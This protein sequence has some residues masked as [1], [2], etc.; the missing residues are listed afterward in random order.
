MKK[1]SNISLGPGAS[2]LILIFVVLS[3]T[4][5][6]MLSLMTARNDERLSRR[7]AE[8][9]ED[10]YTLYEQAEKHYAELSGLAI[11]LQQDAVAGDAFLEALEDALPEWAALDGEAIVWKET[12]GTRTLDCA[13]AV[14]PERKWI[15]HTLSTSIA[16]G[17]EG[18]EEDLEEDS[19]FE[20]EDAGMDGREEET[21]EVE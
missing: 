3:M 12:D 6:G 1:R 11:G 15:R 21:E 14:Q 10:V 5:L 13:M 20:D 2:S 7:S 9:I 19:G 17:I 16:D 4:V 18:F 8:V